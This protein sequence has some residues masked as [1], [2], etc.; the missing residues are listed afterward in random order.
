MMKTNREIYLGSYVHIVYKALNEKLSLPRFEN[1]EVSWL[2]FVS[3]A[4]KMR[5][6]RLSKYMSRR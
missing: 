6:R 1:R 2:D 4:W 3:Y 5:K